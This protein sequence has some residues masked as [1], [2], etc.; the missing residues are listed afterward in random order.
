MGHAGS[1]EPL[2]MRLAGVDKLDARRFAAELSDGVDFVEQR[3]TSDKAGEPLTLIAVVTLTALSLK[4][5]GQ[6]LM[7]DEA[8]HRRNHGPDRYPT[9]AVRSGPS[10]LGGSSSAPSSEEASSARSANP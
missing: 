1:T 3:L 9:A 8:R 4:T 7:K 10:K 6:W 5:L 2:K